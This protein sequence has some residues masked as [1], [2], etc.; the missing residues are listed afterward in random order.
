MHHPYPSSFVFTFNSYRSMCAGDHL[1]ISG[2]C[3]QLF[4]WR[5]DSWV[6]PLGSNFVLTLQNSHS[7]DRGD[8]WMADFSAWTCLTSR[9][10]ILPVSTFPAQELSRI[11]IGELARY[12]NWPAHL[13]QATLNWSTL[14]LMAGWCAQTPT[15]GFWRTSGHCVYRGF[16]G[17]QFSSKS[18]LSML[19]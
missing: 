13:P 11:S 16:V 6:W 9:M 15:S 14:P 8:G 19:A 7:K 2:P 18:P 10:W 17:I 4:V 1:H 12:R 5:L 3:W